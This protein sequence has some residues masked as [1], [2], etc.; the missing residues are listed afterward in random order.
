[1]D[2]INKIMTNGNQDVIANF[3]STLQ[4]TNESTLRVTAE[5]DDDATV[6]PTTPTQPSKHGSPTIS[7]YY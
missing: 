7:N 5:E 1:M 4:E 3:P 2:P 6:Q